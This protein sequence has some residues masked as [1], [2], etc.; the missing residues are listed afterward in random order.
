M[1]IR[2]C[3]QSNL[4]NNL[5]EAIFDR[6]CQSRAHLAF[7]LMQRLIETIPR[8]AEAQSILKPTWNTLRTTTPD[9]ALELIGGN[10]NYSRTLL[11][12]LYLALQAHTPDRATISTK[13]PVKSDSPSAIEDT[14]VVLEILSVVVAQGFRSLTTLLHEDATKVSPSDYA[15]INAILHSCLR[16]SGVERHPEQLVA[17]FTDNHTARYA[18]TLLSWSDQLAIGDDPVY[19]ELSM[20]FLLELSTVPVLAEAM[21]V[22]GVLTQISATNLMQYFRRIG[23]IGPFNEPTTMYSIWSRNILPLGLNLLGAIGAPI[24]A[25]VSAFINQFRA[26]LSRSSNS[27]D[28]KAPSPSDPGTGYI[29]LGM[30]SEVHSLALIGDILEAFREAG[31]SAGI[32]AADVAQLSWDRHQVKEDIENWLQRRKTLRECILASNEKEEIWARQMPLSALNNAENRLEEKV[33]AEMSAALS[34]LGD[35]EL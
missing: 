18:C 17:Q 35:V 29:T 13:A 16:I 9:L 14:Q 30:A 28:T 31:P 34:I 21:A 5:P 32:V 19:G 10:A 25:E 15:L 24:A 1:V 4:D 2:D 22:E 3:L 26:Q 7:A 20:T 12:I 33:V 8:S 23:G 6:L 11:K 27:F